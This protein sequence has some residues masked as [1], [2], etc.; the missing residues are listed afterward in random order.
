MVNSHAASGENVSI[1]KTLAAYH[2]A[3][4]EAQT[5]ELERLLEPG[6]SL[7]HITGYVQP[8]QEWPQSAA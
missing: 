1:L 4:V 8:K 2:R 3:M 7:V 6:Y 5:T